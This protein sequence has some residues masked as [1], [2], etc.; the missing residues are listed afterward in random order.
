[1]LCE[2]MSCTYLDVWE[3]SVGSFKLYKRDGVHLIEKGVEV[4]AR[5][6]DE[7]LILEK[8]DIDGT[9][10]VERPLAKGCHLNHNN[11]NKMS[12]FY[13]NARSIRN[14]FAELKSYVSLE[15]NYR[16]LRRSGTILY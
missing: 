3:D 15:K 9:R 4:F 16:K 6:M 2:S 10:G 8:P 7:R 5:K 13:T 1:M 14:K 11:G 12:C